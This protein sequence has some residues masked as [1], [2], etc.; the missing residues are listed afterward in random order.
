[1]GTLSAML[2]SVVL[3]AEGEPLSADELKVAVAALEESHSRLQSFQVQYRMRQEV[4]PGVT[5]PI[6]QPAPREFT[7]EW[8]W[9]SGREQCLRT[10]E[11]SRMEWWYDREKTYSWI[12]DSGDPSKLN[13]VIIEHWRAEHAV[14]YDLALVTGFGGPYFEGGVIALVKNAMR[15]QTLS[16]EKTGRGWKLALGKQNVNRLDYEIALILDHRHD[17]RLVFWETANREHSLPNVHRYIVDEFQ[18]ITDELD[19]SSIWYPLR[20]H[21]EQLGVLT[22]L[23]IDSVRINLNLQDSR[24]TPPEMPFGTRVEEYVKPGELPK[25]YLVGGEDAEEQRLAALVAIAKRERDRLDREGKTFDATPGSAPY[26]LVW[27]ACGGLLLV[28]AGFLY[29]RRRAA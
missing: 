14:N 29:R 13:R 16:G 11:N 19:G 23:D 24:F 25:T 7:C 4:T 18:A 5:N 9:R 3:G 21:M 6:A 2:L 27:M 15:N 26:G 8:S 10:D 28:V 20:A 1:M 22:R 17:Y 12:F